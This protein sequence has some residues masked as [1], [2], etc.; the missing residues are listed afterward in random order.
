MQPTKLTVSLKNFVLGV[1]TVQSQGLE[2]FEV[3]N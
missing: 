1:P 2:R 3:R